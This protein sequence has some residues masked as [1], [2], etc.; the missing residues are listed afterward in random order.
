MSFIAPVKEHRSVKVWL[1]KQGKR[2]L[3]IFSPSLT[4]F[5]F[6]ELHL[7]PLLQNTHLKS[8]ERT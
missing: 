1:Y 3:L 5:I 8:G 7:K 6:I 2:A 4:A